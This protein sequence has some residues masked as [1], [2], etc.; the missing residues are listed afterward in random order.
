[1]PFIYETYENK[2]KIASLVHK[3]IHG[4]IDLL[5]SILDGISKLDTLLYS[6][7]T[8]TQLRSKLSTV[9][10]SSDII[11]SLESPQETR[12]S[13]YRF[14]LKGSN[15][16]EIIKY[17]LKQKYDFKDYL[18][19]LKFPDA[20][21]SDWDTCILINP[22]LSNDQFTSVFETLVPII[23]KYLIDLSNLISTPPIFHEKIEYSINLANEIIG[24]M[25][26]YNQFTK[27]P[28]VYKKDKQ[29]LIHI[30]DDTKHDPSTISLIESIG[31]SGK[32]LFVSSNRDGGKEPNTSNPP[33]FY[34]GRILLSVLASKTA[35]IPVE[36]LDVSI[37]YQNDD[38][39][40]SWESYSEYHV[41][42]EKFDFRVIS[43]TG[44]Y[45]NLTKCILNA[46]VSTNKTKR[47]KKEARKQRIQKIL[48]NM[49]IPYKNKN[50][51]IHDNLE[52]HKFSSSIVGN[53][54]K[55]MNVTMKKRKP[56]DDIPYEEFEY[57][58]YKF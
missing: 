12:I 32:G 9:S 15:A 55:R 8:R 51:V 20:Y 34:L 11:H 52:K 18:N 29:S 39:K 10:N 2:K 44:L 33:K 56:D 21:F 48:D 30:V 4:N 16:L 6:D 38:L 37:E 3:I 5:N 35:W 40:F 23:Q 54:R 27:Y 28:L 45:F 26:K 36:I 42:N 22:E 47:N 57:D 58:P 7:E 24:Y 17:Y 31:Q 49:I 19:L 41:Q 53:I 43:A 50:D 13:V 1:M 46:N 14:F 25:S